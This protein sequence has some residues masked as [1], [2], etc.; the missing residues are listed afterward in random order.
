MK[1][2]IAV[3]LPIALIAMVG[4]YFFSAPTSEITHYE[5]RFADNVDSIVT[6]EKRQMLYYILRDR[7]R[8]LED[9]WT[10]S[11]TDTLMQILSKLSNDFPPATPPGRLRLVSSQV[12]IPDFPILQGQSD[13][14]RDADGHIAMRPSNG[15][16]IL[17]DL[18]DAEK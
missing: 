18:L 13:E 11:E 2:V 7:P 5:Q 16:A 4:E 15:L 9:R 14:F 12:D 17:F 3:V 1:T 6:A 8:R 10:E